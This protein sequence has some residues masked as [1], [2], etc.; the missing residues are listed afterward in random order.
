[1]AKCTVLAGA[2]MICNFNLSIYFLLCIWD[3]NSEIT[4]PVKIKSTKIKLEH[5][6]YKKSEDPDT[7]VSQLKIEDNIRMKNNKING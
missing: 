3:D 2:P 1:M 6:K 7:S 5:K 4:D